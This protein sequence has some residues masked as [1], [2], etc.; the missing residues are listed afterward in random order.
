MIKLKT[1][2]FIL[3]LFPIIASA[4][5]ETQSSSNYDGASLS[6]TPA[7]V[8]SDLSFLY[9]RTHQNPDFTLLVTEPN[10]LYINLKR[11]LERLEREK[12]NPIK[13]T[14]V[15]N[16]VSN[17]V[18]ELKDV[19][20][21]MQKLEQEREKLAKEVP[22]KAQ[23]NENLLLLIK[24]YESISPEKVASLLKQMPMAVSMQIVKMMNPKKSSQVLSAMD[25]RMATEISK[26][27]IQSTSISQTQNQGVQ[28]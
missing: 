16:E 3:I 14:E 8:R 21:Q 18:D 22:Q 15:R 1:L 24:L 11:E 26:R 13:A 6:K 4:N 19:Q 23:S 7:P 20:N 10:S 28:K 27:L 5:P 2:T 25:D 9:E 12:A 17:K